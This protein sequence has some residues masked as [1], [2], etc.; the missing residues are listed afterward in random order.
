MPVQQDG[1][2]GTRRLE[3]AP[4][5]HP[6]QWLSLIIFGAVICGALVATLAALVGNS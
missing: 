5:N 3:D 2:L 4:T 1:V 6:W